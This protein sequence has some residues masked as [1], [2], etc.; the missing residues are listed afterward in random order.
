MSTATTSAARTTIALCLMAAFCEGIDLQAAG[1]A[2]SGI[3]PLYKPADDVLANFFAASTFGLFIGALLG[4]RLADRLGRRSVLIASIA[5]FGLFSLL[6]AFAWDMQT[7]TL[8]RFFTGLGLGGAFPMVI[9]MVAEASV[10]ERRTANTAIAY[11]GL[12]IGGVIVSTIALLS[13]AANWRWIFLIGGIAPLLVALSM[14][15]KLAESPDFRALQNA[16]AEASATRDNAGNFMQIMAQGRAV[17]T[18]LLWVSFFLALIIVYLLLNWLPTLLIGNGLSRGQATIAQILFNAGGAIAALSMGRL[19]VGSWRMPSLVA[20]AVGVPAL[21]Y[22]L[23]QIGGD[24]VTAATTV[25][26]LGLTALALQA[27]LYASA[28]PSY[29]TWIRGVGV[30]AVVAVGRVG[31]IVGPKLGGWL[32]GLGHGSAQLLI[33]LLPIAILGSLAALALALHKPKEH[34]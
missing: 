7:L 4:G 3:A 34:P 15:L 8:A 28:P 33:D 31:S 21:L 29:P 6:T 19:L 9:T 1:V 26:L 16:G 11:A 5:A 24:F 13:G 12:P 27:F 17:R 25:F 2:A 32:K 10:A 30:G 20:A 22:L 18:L 14:R 23:A